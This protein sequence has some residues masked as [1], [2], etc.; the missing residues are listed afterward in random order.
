[1]T[2]LAEPMAWLQ[3][4][5]FAISVPAGCQ[6]DPREKMGLGNL[7]CEMVQRGCGS[8]DSRKFIE[9]LE[10]LGVDSSSSVSNSHTSFA[11]A[12]PAD[13]LNE[14][15]NIYA[16]VLR[17]PHMP[18]DQLEDGR[19]VCYQ[20]VR[21]IEDDLAQK[22]MIELRRRH[23]PEPFGRTCQG[24]MESVQ[25][26]TQSDVQEFFESY[27]R[28]QGTIIS[29][30]GNVDFE[31][32]KDHLQEI[33]GDWQSKPNPELN[34]EPPFG[35]NHHIEHDSNQTHIALAYASV[36]YRDPEYFKARGV[37]GVLS[38]GMSSRLFTEV[39][40]KRGLCYS[41]FAS[42]HSMKDFGCVVCYSGTSSDRAQETLD[43][44][45]AELARLQ[46]GIE[47]AELDRL[48]VQI[49]SGLIMQQES[50]RTR[51]SAIAGDWYH[52][53]RVRTL[54]ELNEIVNSLT[55]AD[56]DGYIRENPFGD[57]NLVTLGPHPLEKPGGVSTTAT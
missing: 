50:S 32:T 18:E 34:V 30:A 5:A 11:G 56:I 22:T 47:P 33:L 51:A 27:Y 55:V 44:L 4:A 39:R 1:M 19:M 2:L 7:T 12:M 16:D 15:L 40:E 31:R 43:V 10:W 3:S 52:L 21:S 20:E 9:D 46:D 53:G 38:D 6:L 24:T 48:K 28:P 13:S 23:Y 14:A 57:F 17:K 45:V 49:R 25:S 29:I 36:P 42:L 8:R 35:G 54:D 26:L 37:I 41:V